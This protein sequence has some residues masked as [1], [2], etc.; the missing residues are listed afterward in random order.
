M[1]PTYVDQ[2]QNVGRN[3][4]HEEGRK[5]R[6][7]LSTMMT[8]RSSHIPMLTTIDR[9]NST[10]DVHPDLLEPQQLRDDDVAGDERPVLQAS[11]GPVRRFIIMKPSYA[12]PPYQAMN[13]STP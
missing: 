12:L 7:R 9:T 4:P 11:T 3:M 1:V 2:S 8:K 13:A 6:C 10:D 5:S